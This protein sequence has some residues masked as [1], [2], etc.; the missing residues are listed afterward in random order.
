MQ[1]QISETT[2]VAP[3]TPPFED[4]HVLPLSHI[5]NDRNL[6]VSFRYLRVYGN[7]PPTPSSDPFTVISSALSSAL[8]HY[9]PLAGSLRHRP[10]GR[11]EL[12]CSKGQGVPIIRATVNCTLESL[13]YLD[14]PVTHF[15]EQLVPTPGAD[16]GL[17]NPCMLQLTMFDCGGFTLG[18][19]IYHSLCDGLG[20]TQFFN[21]MAEYARGATSSPVKPVWDRQTLLGPRDPPI[22]E[23]DAPIRQFL[24]LDGGFSPYEQPI[25]PVVRE[26]FQV[27]DDCLDRFKSALLEKSGLN[28]TTFEALGAF[29]WRA[30]VKASKIPSD[31]IVKYVYALNIRKIVKPPLPGGY[32]GNGCVPMYAKI[33]AIDLVVKPLWETAELI[34]KSKKNANDEYVR[35]FVDFQA[36][37]FGDGI[38][39]GTEASG[40]TDWRH[41]GHSTVDFGWGGPVTVL[42]LSRHLLGG[43]EPCYFLPYS[44]A[45]EGNK[46]G[47]LVSVTLRESAMP[48]FKAEME[49]FSK[50]QFHLS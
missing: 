19:A 47:F 9:Y 40:F 27:R 8:I 14:D 31:E 42:P 34:K 36:L 5:D 1:V 15:V 33:R 25:G 21:V 10:D 44:S 26:I 49:Q 7:K 2:V 37:H 32:W 3:S 35:S 6:R 16:E 28:F 43:L 46:D 50:E 29:I 45:R 24:S 17:V 23:E 12:V 30:K 11:L 18:A 48:A 20:A 22:V 39:A 41:L 13:N 38:S 4:D